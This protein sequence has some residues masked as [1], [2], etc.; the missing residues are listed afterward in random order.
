MK[1]LFIISGGVGSE[2]EV[3]LA[4][5]KNVFETLQGDGV[6]CEEIIIEK[7]RSFL[8]RGKNMSEQDG[9]LLLKHEDAL[10]FQLIHGTYGEDGEFVRKLEE[11]GVTYIG[12][13]SDVLVLTID[14]YAT[15]KVLEENDVH[16]P[17][18]FFIT[19]DTSIT[20]INIPVFPAIVKPNK[21]GSSI[22]VKKVASI[23]ELRA[24]LEEYLHTYS[25]V[26]VQK[27]LS[28]REFTCGVLEMDGQCV[29]LAVSEVIISADRLFDYDAKYNSKEVIEITPAEIDN[30]LRTKIQNLALHVHAVCGCKDISRTDMMLDENGE[31]V[32]L[33]INTIPGMTRVSFI[34]A[35]MA[36]SGYSLSDFVKGMIEKYSK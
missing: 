21:E 24:A 16:T 6:T 12:S 17:E 10:V 3:S 34:P 2:R 33:E 35:E 25:E 20:D 32:V 22:G 7:D 27:C 18:S 13:H 11:A 26:V 15:E 4:S 1:K 36:A 9:L 19:Q 30:D 29:A 28:G 14:K 8:V 5:G 23:Q 31:L